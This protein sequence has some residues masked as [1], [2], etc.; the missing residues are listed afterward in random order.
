MRIG[1]ARRAIR[2]EEAC[3]NALQ[4]VSSGHSALAVA[5]EMSCATVVSRSPELPI[6]NP[7]EQDSEQARVVSY[8]VTDAYGCTGPLKQG[9]RWG[10]GLRASTLAW[11]WL[12][13]PVSVLARAPAFGSWGSVLAG[14]RSP[15]VGA[16]GGA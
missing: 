8:A 15:V 9:R 16:G 13:S 4:D 11:S 1:T 6:L 7:L 10:L 3:G 2:I 14:R 12:L 5:G